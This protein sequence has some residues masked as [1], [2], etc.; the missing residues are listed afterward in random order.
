M[1]V[2]KIVIDFGKHDG[3]LMTRV[4][5]DYLRW[6][7]NMDRHYIRNGRDYTAMARQELNRRG[8][9]YDSII[10]SL[11]AVDRFS[12]RFPDR[13][14]DRTRGLASFLAAMSDLAWE[15]GRV[16]ATWRGPGEKIVKKKYDGIV[17]V[18]YCNEKGE[19]LVLK[20]VM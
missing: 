7:A 5:V 18:F 15:Q 17:F 2:K 19:P 3:Q 1:S 10:P 16:I 20:T 6:L 9:A 8:G 4:P 11:H 14:E 13:W 12:T